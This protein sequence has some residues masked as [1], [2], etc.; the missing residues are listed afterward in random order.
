VKKVGNTVK[1]SDTDD[2]WQLIDDD[3]RQIR[4]SARENTTDPS[5][6]AKRVGR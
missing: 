6:I 3:L 1:K 2:Y 5:A 4:E